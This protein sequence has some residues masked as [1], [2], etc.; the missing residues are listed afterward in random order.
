MK[1]KILNMMKRKL[2]WMFNI[3]NSCEYQNF[4]VRQFYYREKYIDF[5]LIFIIKQTTHFLFSH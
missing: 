1:V 5:V 3:N 4:L 2:A